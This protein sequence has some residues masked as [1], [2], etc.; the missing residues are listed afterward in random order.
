MSSEGPHL[1]ERLRHLLAY[2]R[3]AVFEGPTRGEASQ[4]PANA[5]LVPL[6]PEVLMHPWFA[7]RR[8]RYLARLEEA[9]HRGFVWLVDKEPVACL[10]TTCGQ[11]STVEAPFVLGLRL[12]VE[13]GRCYVWDC[14][15]AP[16]WRGRGFY[17][18]GILAVGA[19]GGADGAHTVRML[20][21]PAN[22]A[23]V[24]GIEAAGLRLVG[25]AG[26]WKVGPL[27][28]VRFGSVLFWR[29]RRGLVQFPSAPK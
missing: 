13:P 7:D 8:E 23:S 12:T 28:V 18:E 29:S 16:S 9:R 17:R 20:A 2:R 1:R 6:G 21:E 24:R 3:L 11:S 25:T 19:I 5:R 22:R 26:V 10:W 15:T 27:R 4:P 14:H